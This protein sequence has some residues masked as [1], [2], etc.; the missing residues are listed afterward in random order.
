MSLF[1]IKAHKSHQISLECLKSIFHLFNLG[2]HFEIFSNQMD[3]NLMSAKIVEMIKR[4]VPV[5][6]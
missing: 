4:G 6:S 3:E 5:E 2:K 1:P